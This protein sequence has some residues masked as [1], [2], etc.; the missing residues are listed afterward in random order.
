M[1]EPELSV[2]AEIQKAFF[3][4]EEKFEVGFRRAEFYFRPFINL[5]GDFYW[6][7]HYSYQSV[8]VIGDCTGHGIMGAMIS[9]SIMTLVMQYFQSLP[10]V[11]INT[12][13]KDIHH[14]IEIIR[15]EN[16]FIDAELGIIYLDRRKNR[17]RFSGTGI[18]AIHKNRKESTLLTTNKSNF[19]QGQQLEYKM[20]I[21]KGEQL[22][23]YTDGIT[24]Q[25]DANDKSRLKNSG[26][27][28]LI[29]KLPAPF[30]IKEFETAFDQFKGNVEKLDDQTALLLTY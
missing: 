7:K 10:P 28:N 2:S 26:L 8:Y 12:S 4:K 5:G 21:K 27:F 17:V 24:D 6:C 16:K 25:F 14:L 23:L 18:N 20:D 22:Y 3:L 13:L 19:L 11:T 15:S 29:S 9:M 30:T 1:V